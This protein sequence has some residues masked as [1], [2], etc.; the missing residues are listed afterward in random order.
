MRIFMIN[1]L[2]SIKDFYEIDYDKFY[3]WL[4][5]NYNMSEGFDDIFKI[6]C[7]Y[8]SIIFKKIGFEIERYELGMHSV[9]RVDLCG[10]K[11]MLHGIKDWHNAIKEKLDLDC[12]SVLMDVLEWKN[13]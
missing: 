7:E 6:Y 8:Y 3:V 11:A 12:S 2:N 1:I 10:A 5:N 9:D 4:G 13:H